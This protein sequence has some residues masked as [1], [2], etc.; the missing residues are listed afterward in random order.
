MSELPTGTITFLFTDIQGSTRLLRM[1]GRDRYAAALGDHRRLLRDAFDAAGG[2]EQG[3]EGDSFYV[4]FPRA[5]DA[6]C[7]AVAG[8]RALAAHD[9]PENEAFAVRMGCHTGE[10]AIHDMAYVGLAIHRAH[11]ISSLAHGGQ[12][13][14][15]D[16]T[17]QLVEDD[18]PSGIGLRSLGTHALKDFDRPER[19]WQLVIGGLPNEFPPLKTSSPGR[20]EPRRLRVTSPTRRRLVRAALAGVVAAAVGSAALVYLDRDSAEAQAAVPALAGNALA[21]ID[22]DQ[23][24]VHDQS[25]GLRSP[26]AVALGYGSIWV[27]NA[28]SHDVTRLDPETY[29]KTETIPVGK[30]PSGIAIGA[31]AVWVTNSFSG[32]LS[33]VDPETNAEVRTVPVGGFPVAVAY[34]DGF[35]WVADGGGTVTVVD[36]GKNHV[37]REFQL[38]GSLRGIAFGDG[39]AWVTRER[40]G[41]L[42]RLE[43]LSRRVDTFETEDGPA[44]VTFGLDA[45]WVANSGAGSVTRVD[46]ATLYETQDIPLKGSPSSIALSS[47]PEMLWVADDANNAVVPVEVR[48]VTPPSEPAV[49]LGGPPARV[50]ADGDDVFALAQRPVDQHLGGTLEVRQVPA[51]ESLDPATA[52]DAYAWAVRLLL[53]DGLVAFKKIGTGDGTQLVPDLALEVPSPTNDGRRYTFTLR[54]QVEYSDGRRVE[55]GDIRYAIE[56]LFEKGS[57]GAALFRSIVGADDCSP[58][59]ICDLSR[60][61]NVDVA[62][63]TVRFEL[64]AADDEFLYKLATPY[65]AAVPWDY[66]EGLQGELAPP[67]T[68]PYRIARYAPDRALVLTRNPRFRP[69][70]PAAQPPGYPERIAF[71]LGET[72]AAA[73]AAV[74]RGDADLY[75][76]PLLPE[77]RRELATRFASRLHSGL[78]SV[79]KYLAAGTRPT[80]IRR[81]SPGSA[82]RGLARFCAPR[83]N[84]RSSRGELDWAQ[85][86]RFESAVGHVV[87][88]HPAWVPLVQGADF[89]FVS[90]RLGNYHYHPLYGPLLSQLW[91]K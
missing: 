51:F 41:D 45:V 82:A 28:A 34:G 60:G 18:L 75:L 88:A 20:P 76:G 90:E 13:L 8:Q 42:L 6:V 55:P 26:A 50:A 53:N 16:T 78:L 38:G 47:K 22:V 58:R 52:D 61:I 48:A 70:S 2:I 4:V 87:A 80:V 3:T 21:V 29:E 72:P 23:K 91:V 64:T 81:C 86:A 12:V 5:N 32:T 83:V 77:T 24:V 19:V 35:V 9:W 49:E 1:L 15:S 40:S 36:A 44:G 89:H 85:P 39:A 17:A 73:L 43:A 10:P 74:E 33:R 79:S 69:W 14:L 37:F 59:T 46:P 71:R 67:A 30:G 84:A 31:G 66:D 56:R 54:S 11:R 68:G 27:A 7:A 62:T 63:R 57:R 65:A 25:E